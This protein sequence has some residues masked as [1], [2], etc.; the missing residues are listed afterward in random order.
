[1]RSSSWAALLQ[2]IPPEK[3]DDLMLVTKSGQEINVNNILRIDQEFVAFRG[4]LAASQDAGR[5]F[6]VPYSNIDYFGYQKPIKESDFQEMF[7]SFSLPDPPPANGEAAAP[8][9]GSRNPP[10]IKS[11][12][13]ERFRSRSG[14]TGAAAGTPLAPSAHAQR[15]AADG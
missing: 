5:L 9:A 13:L 6:F 1:M 14:T 11:A 12:V 10:A 15:S 7:G 2:H 4:R 3:Q 8:A